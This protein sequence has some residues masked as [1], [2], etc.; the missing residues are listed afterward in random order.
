MKVTKSTNNRV[1]REDFV[2]NTSLKNLPLLG[3]I[4]TWSIPYGTSLTKSNVI[5]ALSKASLDTSEA[6]E[7]LPSS[8]FARACHSMKEER[9]IDIVKAD[10]RETVFQFTKKILKDAEM[11]YKKET[12]IRLDTLAGNVFCDDKDLEK[13]ARAE[14]RRRMEERTTS[15]ITKIV[16]RLFEKEGD[17]FSLRDRGGVYFVPDCYTYF[18]DKVEN[19]LTEVGARLNRFPV[20]KGTGNGDRAVQNAVNDALQQLINDHVGAI[21]DF[22]V[23]TRPDTLQ[24]A[25]AKIKET[26]IKIEAYAHYLK[27]KREGLLESLKGAES[28]LKKKI[29]QLT[30][31]MA[32]RD[33]EKR[34]S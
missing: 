31:E 29:Q 27:G 9:A 13:F 2:A 23:T 18:T 28:H 11:S 14:V 16:Q 8:A 26:R 5:A 19:F 1:R 10:E 7:I 12:F 24:R 25:S 30:V 4:I 22:K 3:E 34:L 6:K 17:L 32:D 20:P 21:D 33:E 15:D